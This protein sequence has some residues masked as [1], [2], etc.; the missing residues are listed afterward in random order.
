M[1][2]TATNMNKNNSRNN[3]GSTVHPVKVQ[4]NNWDLKSQAFQVS[5][6]IPVKKISQKMD[7]EM[8]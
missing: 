2:M 1:F 6:Q 3:S 8:S 7:H 4:S 5:E